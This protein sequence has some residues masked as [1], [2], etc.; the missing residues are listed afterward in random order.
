MGVQKRMSEVLGAL[1]KNVS[2]T[3]RTK[4]ETQP[5]K[6]KASENLLPRAHLIY[7]LIW[8]KKST[9]SSFPGEWPRIAIIG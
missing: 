8:G 3:A 9:P 7:V 1:L 6:Y 5:E 2:A 4:S